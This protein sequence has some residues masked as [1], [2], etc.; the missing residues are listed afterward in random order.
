MQEYVA[1][2]L[3]RQKGNGIFQCEGIIEVAL[4]RK[5][6]PEWQNGLL[7][8]IGGKIEPGEYPL[9]AMIRE[10]QEEAGL[11]ILDWQHFAT[12]N[13]GGNREGKFTSLLTLKTMHKF[14]VWK[15]NK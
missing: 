14:K 3:F 1:G 6:K 2:F 12:M 10:F 8:G 4:I 11:Y 9:G 15:K 13:C 5:I 7:N